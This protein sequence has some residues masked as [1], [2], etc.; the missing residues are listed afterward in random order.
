[1]GTYILGLFFGHFAHFVS[2]YKGKESFGYNKELWFYRK[3]IGK[4]NRLFKI[5][6]IFAPLKRKTRKNN[7]K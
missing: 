5:L 7:S 6:L 2:K 3:K 1:M 4:S